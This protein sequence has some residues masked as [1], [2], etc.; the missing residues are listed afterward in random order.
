MYADFS[1]WAV[2]G[3]LVP[4]GLCRWTCRVGGYH[5]ELGAKDPGNGVM[6]LVS[7]T[8]ETREDAWGDRPPI[9]ATAILRRLPMD[10]MVGRLRE[11]YAIMMG[12]LAEWPPSENPLMALMQ[13]QARA[14]AKDAEAAAIKKAPGRPPL[15]DAAY[16][17]VADTYME[18]IREGKDPIPYIRNHFPKPRPAW[19]TGTMDKPQR[20]TVGTWI[21]RAQKRGYLPETTQGVR[22]HPQVIEADRLTI[23]PSLPGAT[24]T[25]GS[26]PTS[27]DS[28]EREE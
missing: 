14:G 22:R 6:Q 28:T 20:S 5:V 17:W 13:E 10:A 18:A 7:L 9:T 12:A 8:V 2:V 1:H 3:S 11:D 19:W 27:P 4:R 15:P 26:A 23:T 24:I 16:R 21:G 25:T